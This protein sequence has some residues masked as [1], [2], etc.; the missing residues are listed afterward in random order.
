MS[1]DIVFRGVTGD[2]L[3][4]VHEKKLR[5]VAAVPT[6][7]PSWNA[8]CMEEGGREG[9]ANGWLVVLAGIPGTGK[10]SLA[11]NMAAAAVLDGRR[12]GIVNF[13]MS[14]IGLVTRYLSILSGVPRYK[15]ERG[16]YFDSEAFGEAKEY[17]INVSKKK[18]GLLLTNQ[19]SVFNLEDIEASYRALTDK[20]CE[21][22]VVDYVQLVNVQGAE[23][24]FQRTN[25]VAN[26]L[27]HLTKQYDVATVA[28]SQFNREISKRRDQP[29]QREGLSGGSPWENNANQIVL[30]DH[31]IRRT[32]KEDNVE[33]T[34]LIGD[35]NRHG[36]VPFTFPIRWDWDTARCEEYMEGDLDQVLAESRVRTDAPDEEAE[37]VGPDGTR[38]E[39]S[40][41]FDE[42]EEAVGG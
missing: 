20:G 32:F 3:D 16:K 39:T 31:S 41:L 28:I 40:N 36:P 4:V 33:F 8:V 18:G 6:P 17:V 5:P 22:I 7:F 15:L 14:M 35:K 11:L 24:I 19:H 42:L 38:W 12:V 10:S 9:I 30:L 1:D 23:G 2:V 26:T 13:E 29:P 25:R 37:T 21:L 34:Q 27:R